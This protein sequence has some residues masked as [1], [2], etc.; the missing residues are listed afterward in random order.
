[1]M[2]VWVPVRCHNGHTA[3]ASIR[4]EGLEAVYEGVPRHENCD[5]NKWEMGKGWV[6][7]GEPYTGE[8]R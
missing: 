7:D 2:R 4:I 6:A 5:C 1:M 8:R 3:T